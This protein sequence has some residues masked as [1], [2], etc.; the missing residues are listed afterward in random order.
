MLEKMGAF[1]DARL[2]GYE[3]HQLTCIEGARE[4]YPFTAQCLP[5]FDGARVL[6]LGC[7]TGLE[8][9]EY[10]KINPTASIFHVAY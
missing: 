9:G 6:D 4:F 1:F 5:R 2:D 3:E 8:L 7:G 10:F